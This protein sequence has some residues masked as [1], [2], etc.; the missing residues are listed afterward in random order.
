[1]EMNSIC[2]FLWKPYQMKGMLLDQNWFLF[3][4]KTK[5]KPDFKPLSKKSFTPPKFSS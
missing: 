2:D 3:Y 5:S 4:A 1:M